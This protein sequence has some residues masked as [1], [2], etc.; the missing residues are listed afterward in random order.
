MSF[1]ITE[2]RFKSEMLAANGNMVISIQGV[3]SWKGIDEIILK[4]REEHNIESIFMMFDSDIMGNRQVFN[5]I[6]AMTIML[7]N[8]IPDLKIRFAVWGIKYGKGV[9]DCVLAGNIK[10][11]KYVDAAQFISVC[12]NTFDMLLK[13][14]NVESFKK[15]KGED[16]KEFSKILQKENERALLNSKAKQPKRSS[17]V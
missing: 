6:S 17:V 5:S 2:G 13:K 12:N 16:R 15:M 4:M 8:K 10:Y 1:C 14:Y 11:V 7:A 3:S 9:D